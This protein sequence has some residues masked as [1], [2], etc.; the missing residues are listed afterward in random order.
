MTQ[1]SHP[2][3]A[4]SVPATSQEPIKQPSVPQN[5]RQWGLP[6]AYEPTAPPLTVL[7]YESRIAPSQLLDKWSSRTR[8]TLRKSSKIL[9]ISISLLGGSIL[10]VY[11]ANVVAV[12]EKE[13]QLAWLLDQKSNL[14]GR[15]QSPSSDAPKDTSVN[16]KI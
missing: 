13:R 1:L 15:L 10:C 9:G 11:L 12:W 14:V 6:K 16:S 4:E 2:T 5:R 8:K 3:S 7:D